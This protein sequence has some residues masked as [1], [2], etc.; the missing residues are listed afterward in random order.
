MVL[1]TVV[2]A[3]WEKAKSA[4]LRLFLAMRI[5]LRFAN[6]PK[7]FRSCCETETTNAEETSGLKK[8]ADGALE[9]R[10]LFQATVAVVPVE[11]PCTTLLL[12]VAAWE[13]RDAAVAL[14]PVP[15]MNGLLMGVL[16]SS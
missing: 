7:P 14:T 2:M 6:V 3:C 13:N 12:Y 11:N 9:A 5:F 8:L 10:E 1:V 4:S 16:R 15:E